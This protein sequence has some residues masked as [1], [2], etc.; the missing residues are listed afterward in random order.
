MP[1]YVFNEEH[2]SSGDGM[3]TSVWGPSIWHF[4]HTISFN[5]PVDPSEE[6]KRHYMEFIKNLEYILPCKFCRVNLKKNFKSLPITM[7]TM[8]SRQTFSRYV[9]DLH[10]HINDMLNKKSKLSY[11]DVR[12]RY[13]HFRARCVNTKPKTKKRKEKGCVKPL[14]GKKSKCVLRI[15]PQTKKAKSF[16]IDKSCLRY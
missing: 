13:E 14:H 2:Y 7:E 10:E 4:L 16:D 11:E 8:K 15:I 12:E 9:Y 1:K 3:L 6:D 5:Y